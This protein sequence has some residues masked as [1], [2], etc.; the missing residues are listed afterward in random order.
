MT[1]HLEEK[2]LM[3]SVQGTKDSITHYVSKTNDLKYSKPLER[4]QAITLFKLRVIK[5]VLGFPTGQDSATFW[6]KGTSSKS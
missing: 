4:N 2:S 3:K 6:D 1:L 5:Y